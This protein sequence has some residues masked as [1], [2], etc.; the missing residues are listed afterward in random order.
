MNCVWCGALVR[1]NDRMMALIVAATS[2]C[3]CYECALEWVSEPKLQVLDL[4]PHGMEPH[5]YG[6]RTE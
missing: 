4:D 2:A 5:D 6:R 3:V 1:E